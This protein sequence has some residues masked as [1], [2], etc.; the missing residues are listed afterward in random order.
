LPPDELNIISEDKD[1]GWPYCY[2]DRV[3]DVKFKTGEKGVHCVDT[4]SPVFNYPAHVAP[5][6]IAFIDSN[7]FSPTEQ[8]NLL[9][10][11]HGS[12]STSNPVGYK[13][14]KLTVFAD[15]VAQ[16]EDFITGWQTDGEVLGR[17]V[18]LIFDEEGTLYISDDKAG[19]IYNLTRGL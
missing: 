2:G 8:G 1:Y 13:I 15:S 6:G 3:R 14:V 9:V 10:A 4:Q 11:Y 19:L 12:G 16:A 5:L 17:P 18:D 7:L